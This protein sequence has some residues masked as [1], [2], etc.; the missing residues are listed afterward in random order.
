MTVAEYSGSNDFPCSIDFSFTATGVQAIIVLLLQALGL[1]S[2]P[3]CVEK[4]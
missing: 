3:D 2:A 4:Q 1:T